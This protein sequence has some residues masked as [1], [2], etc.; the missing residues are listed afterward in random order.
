MQAHIPR[1]PS[2]LKL[3]RC[4]PPATL[5]RLGISMLALRAEKGI[6]L[7]NF[8]LANR[9][10]TMKARLFGFAIHLQLLR[11]IARLT[12]ALGKIFQRGAA[13]LNRHLQHLF[14]VRH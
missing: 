12:I 9:L 6:A 2:Y 11:E 4:W 5:S 10:T 8:L 7:S 13:L 14:D 3:Q 1:S